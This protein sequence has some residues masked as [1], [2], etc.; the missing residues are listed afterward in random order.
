M[1]GVVLLWSPSSW[2]LSVVVF[3]ASVTIPLAKL[4]ALSYLLITVQ[5]GSMKSNRE[6]TR[7]YR[8]VAFIGRWSMLDVF[9]DTFVVA[10]VQLQPLMVGGTGAG[11]GVFCSR[12][13]AHHD[14]GRN[15]RPAIDLGPTRGRSCPTFLTRTVFP[16]FRRRPAYPRSGARPSV[17]WIIPIVAAIIGGW[18]A[19][20]KILSEG[21]TITISFRTAE[22]LEAGKTKIKYNGVDIGTVSAV[23]LSTDRQGVIA[24]AKMAAE[25]RDML[26]EDT[27]FWVVRPRISGGTVSG[28]GTLLS[29]SYIGMEVGKSKEKRHAFTGLTVPPV[30]TGDVPGRFFVLKGR[31]PRLP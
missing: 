15:L 3:I 31:E 4:I 22:G 5:R 16:T 8:M 6:R 23:T 18:I 9:V 10:L 30:V 13:R 21:P 26:V 17:V 11:S 24:T 14:C 28:L 20:Q 19:V 7:L 27:Q 25:S 29:G 12:G 2:P 1:E